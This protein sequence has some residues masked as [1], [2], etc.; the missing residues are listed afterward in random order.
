MSPSSRLFSLTATVEN[1]SV[2]PLET[3]VA[4]K[5]VCETDDPILR[6]VYDAGVE[7]F[8]LN[9]V[10]VFMDCPSRERAGWLCD[11]FF[12]ARVEHA[13]PGKTALN[14]TSWKIT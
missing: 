3:S 8:R 1:L 11:S 9:A 14:A 12:T 5:A 7:T 13:P 4:I 6:G 2:V 10:D